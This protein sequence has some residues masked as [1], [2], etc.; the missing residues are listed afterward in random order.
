MP[1]IIWEGALQAPKSP[2]L[3]PHALLKQAPYSNL[4]AKVT[5]LKHPSMHPQNNT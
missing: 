1:T 2:H 4:K 5:T 3:K